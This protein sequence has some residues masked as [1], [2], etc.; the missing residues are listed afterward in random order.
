MEIEKA[1]REN[2]LNQGKTQFMI[3]YE[4]LMQKAEAGDIE[5][6]QLVKKHAAMYKQHSAKMKAK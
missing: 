2:L 5:A 4:S 1:R 3:Y 6:A